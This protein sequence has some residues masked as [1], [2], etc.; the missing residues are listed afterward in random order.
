VKAASFY[1]Q[2]SRLGDGPALINNYSLPIANFT[3][4]NTEGSQSRFEQRGALVLAG[5][6]PDLV[7][8]ES[9]RLTQC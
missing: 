6:P 1:P 4:N 8:I 5:R 7:I 3:G 9:R 2:P